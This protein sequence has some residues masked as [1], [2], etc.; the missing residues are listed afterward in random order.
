M[1]PFYLILTLVVVFYFFLFCALF[2]FL[3][4]SIYLFLVVN[5]NTFQLQYLACL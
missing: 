2:P 3:K 1:I 4:S 5:V